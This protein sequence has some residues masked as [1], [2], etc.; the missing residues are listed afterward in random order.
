MNRLLTLLA[1]LLVVAGVS[2]CATLA[3]ARGAK[4]QGMQKTY[5]ADFETVWR[6]LP[7]VVTSI[8]LQVAG[9]NKQEGYILAQR[10]MTLM[11]YGE[12]VAIFVDRAGGNRT[13][14]EVVSK[15]AMATNIFAPDW[16]PELLQKLDETLRR[17]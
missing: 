3:D 5:D 6:T 4:G 14:V 12:H 9:D 16:A 10:G 13:K 11:S 7:Q 2:G 8:G 17:R 15:R 1:A